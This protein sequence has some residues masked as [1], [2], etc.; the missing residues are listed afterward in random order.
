MTTNK[1][2]VKSLILP[3]ARFCL[4]D[5]HVHSPASYDVRG[6]HFNDLSEEEKDK[7][8]EISVPSIDD[9]VEYQKNVIDKYPAEEFYENIILRRDSLAIEEGFD[10]TED[11]A[12]I[13]ITDHNV[14]EYSCRLSEISWGKRNINRIITLP[15]IELDITYPVQNTTDD[16]TKSH[17][18][19]IF[20]PETSCADIRFAITEASGARWEEGQPFLDVKDLPGFINKLR[21]DFNALCIAAHV[22]SS[23][24]IQKETKLSLM[25]YHDAAIVQLEN[26]LLGAEKNEE[27]EINKQ[28]KLIMDDWDE[29][30]ISLEALKLIGDCGFDAL[31]VSGPDDE[32]HYRNLHRFLPNYGRSVPIICSDSHVSSKIF[33]A[34]ER[35]P[36]LKMKDGLH[37]I[38]SQEFWTELKEHSIRCGETRFSYT[39]P[40]RVTHW[41]EGL[42]IVPDAEDAKRFW[43][44]DE[45]F[46]L[47]F[48][49]NLNCLIGGRGA[50]KSAIVEALGFLTKPT[51]FAQ[52]NKKLD[53]EFYKRAE[54]TLSG[55]KLR[56]CW[57]HVGMEIKKNQRKGI[58]V[59]RYFDPAFKH[60]DI[61]ITDIEG[62]DQKSYYTVNPVQIYRFHEIENLAKPDG[63]RKLFDVI[64]GDEIED[65]EHEIQKVIQNLELQRHQVI[66]CANEIIKVTA[67]N[68]PLRRYIR[69]YV[70]YQ[71]ANKPEVQHYYTDLDESEYA[72][73]LANK[74]VS[75]WEKITDNFSLKEKKLQIEQ[76]FSELAS[77]CFTKE[78]A[79]RNSCNELEIALRKESDNPE[80]KI[81]LSTIDTLDN[82]FGEIKDVFDLCLNKLREEYT[83]RKNEVTKRGLP[84]GGKDRETKKLALEESEE[85]L[86]K[87]R[88]NVNRFDQLFEEREILFQTL[89]EKCKRRTALREKTAELITKQLAQ[90]LDESVL[91]INAEARGKAEHSNFKNWLELQ[92]SDCF[93]NHRNTRATALINNGLMPE[94]LRKLLMDNIEGVDVSQL[95]I[96]R[97]KVSDGK[98]TLDD[99]NNVVE[100]LCAKSKLE[101]ELS[102]ENVEQKLWTDLPNEVKDGL[103]WFPSSKF[104]KTKL[105]LENILELDEIVFDDMPVILLNDRPIET[106]ST[107]R[108][109]EELSP[110]QRCSAVLPILLLNG[111]SP[112]IIDQPEDN[113]DNRLI[114]QVIVN[115]LSNIK[116][117]R[118]VIVATHNPN[119]PVLGDA[120]QT[121]VLRA[122][123][124]KKA[125]LVCSG[126]L[127]QPDIINNITEIM[128]GGRE[129]FQYRQQV[130]QSHWKEIL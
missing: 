90:D 14:C 64:C 18:L 15:A 19:C 33:N 7:L 32:K 11:W 127:D 94:L 120:E 123:E 101:P 40:G 80:F 81:L 117:R 22:S 91:I 51:D 61:E 68:T 106:G 88:D 107:L 96:D 41:I 1:D 8:S 34:A 75:E 85:E 110:G 17:V 98:I 60:Q 104:N 103:I 83:I 45:P 130:Y 55:C 23:K 57:K 105:R 108:P 21:T 29:D 37:N 86:Q 25:N 113:L 9:L 125:V 116:L 24:G 16:K 100:C 74:C 65:L 6:T 13:A 69:N 92:F 59:S 121:I 119:I 109:I 72:G 36:H 111:K 20:S 27:E 47:P 49:R 63:L 78:G 52:G 126:D 93:P 87:Y 82:K 89:T 112:L 42:E 76:I 2:F 54:A 43:P 38:S 71:D 62:E 44:S 28:I 102:E 58:F 77:Y 56:V 95:V 3:R 46:I 30:H 31:Q 35:I 70:E 124:D 129:A 4:C 84:V 10:S 114:R 48:S 99:A 5:F 39:V 26:A 122:I 12:I 50:G 79:I 66:S 118:Q 128:E 73:K 115:V 67:E 53:S 97:D